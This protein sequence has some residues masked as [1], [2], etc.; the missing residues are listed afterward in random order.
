LV[1]YHETAGGQNGSYLDLTVRPDGELTLDGRGNEAS[2]GLLAGEKLETLARLIDALP[3]QSYGPPTPCSE[4]GFFVSVTRGGEVLTFASG[5]CDVSAPAPLT[6]LSQLFQ[7]LAAQA[8]EHRVRPVQYQILTHGIYS[9]IREPGR[10]IVRDRDALVQLL[11]AHRPNAPVAIPRVDFSTQMVVAA[12][13]GDCPGSG[14]ALDLDAAEET[15]SGWLRIRFVRTAPPAD[16]AAGGGITQPFVM[17]AVERR[18]GDVLF[19]DRMVSFCPNP[20]RLQATAAG[21]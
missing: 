2:R 4:D 14:Y 10:V 5:S 13:L 18:P 12:F 19:E 11:K 7:D 3:P 1:R 17:F 6:D 21:L 15:E 20:I 8:G 9:A 16:C